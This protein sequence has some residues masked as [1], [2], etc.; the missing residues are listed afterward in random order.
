MDSTHPE[1]FIKREQRYFT[2]AILRQLKEY[3]H[4]ISTEVSKPQIDIIPDKLR[5][6]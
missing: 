6:P 1:H 2:V 5:F 4:S 3:Q